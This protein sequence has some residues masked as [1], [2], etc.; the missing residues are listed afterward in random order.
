MTR[1]PFSKEQTIRL[2]TPLADDECW[3]VVLNGF[4]IS[5]KADAE[6]LIRFDVE[7]TD[8]TAENNG[9]E[10]QFTIEG[11]FESACRTP[12]C[13]TLED[14][15]KYEIDVYSLLIR[16]DDDT[17]T[18]A[19]RDH[20]MNGY[21]WGVGGSDEEIH[22]ENLGP[23]TATVDTVDPDA[24]KSVLAFESILIDIDQMDRSGVGHPALATAEAV[25]LLEWNTAIENQTRG[26][27]A[28]SARVQLFFKN[29]RQGMK[30]AHI[31]QSEFAL[32]D[33]GRAKFDVVVRHLQFDTTAVHERKGRAGTIDWVGQNT[34]PNSADARKES[35][36]TLD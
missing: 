23:A 21:E 7:V 4:D 18:I 25:H 31:P 17:L 1:I 28:V 20:V 3:T 30:A 8:R 33:A 36:M 2:D 16:G 19:G 6:K 29:W 11:S 10:I 22:S 35:E 34:D 12:E 24:A 5:S 13:E 15:V 26:N 32:K 27:G 14:R 9:T